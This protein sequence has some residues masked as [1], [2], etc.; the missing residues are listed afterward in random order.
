MENISYFCIVKTYSLKKTLL[1]LFLILLNFSKIGAAENATLTKEQLAWCDSVEISLLTCSPHD[2]VYSLYGHTAIRY[3]DKKQGLDL[4]INYGVFSFDKPYFVLRFVFGLTDYEMG[5]VNFDD[6][7]QEYIYYGSKVTQQTINLTPVEKIRIIK[8]LQ[9]NYQPENRVYRYNYFYNNCTTKARDII[10]DN[11]LGKVV[12]GNAINPD[13][14][15]RKLI[16]SCNADHPWARFGND[17][18]LGVKADFETN[19]S[20]QQFLPANLMR[21]FANAKIDRENSME[22]LVKNTSVV[23]DATQPTVEEGFCPTPKL[24]FIFVGIVILSVCA[25]EKKLK[26]K[27]YVFDG[28]IMLLCGFVGIVLFAMLFSQ[29]PT[30]STN[31]QI[32]LFNPVPLVLIAYLI[33]HRTDEAKLRRMWLMLSLFPDLAYICSFVQDYAEGID[34]LAL[35]LLVRTLWNFCFP[36]GQ[37]LQGA[38]TKHVEIRR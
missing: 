33:K 5:I 24:V 8:A 31:L 29:H 28:M 19:R 36:T 37:K 11:I 4:A 16:H 12:Y 27:L 3:K 34:Y 25:I 32:L 17:L 21:D 18:L 38:M 23:V 2:E 15:F 35:F 26:S 7:C 20:E 30:T 9:N 22:P 6:F 1:F 14:S 13:D 10:V